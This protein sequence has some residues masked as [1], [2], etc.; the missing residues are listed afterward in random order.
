[1][2]AKTMATVV[3]LLLVAIFTTAP[4]W[5]SLSSSSS[6]VLLVQAQEY[7]ND[8]NAN[9]AIPDNDDDP[10]AKIRQQ[11]YEK[12]LGTPKDQQQQQSLCVKER[13][14][15]KECRNEMLSRY[16]DEEDANDTRQSK[17][18]MYETEKQLRNYCLELSHLMSQCKIKGIYHST[19]DRENA[20][21]A[22]NN[23]GNGN[24]NNNGNDISITNQLGETVIYGN[25]PKQ[26][27]K[28]RIEFEKVA[29]ELSEW[30]WNIGIR[31]MMIVIILYALFFDAPFTK[32]K[33]VVPTTTTAAAAADADAANEGKEKEEEL[34]D[35]TDKK[36]D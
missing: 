19:L 21:D 11:Q 2:T 5:S 1:M 30:R 14:L 4:S 10:I 31:G 20:A 25:S 29:L 23:N 36:K 9:N 3:F 12:V 32:D 7:D 17:F 24:S 8:A 33:V 15:N 16:G 26:I 27:E 13:I 35:P 22:D 34:K 28:E 18:I 6:F